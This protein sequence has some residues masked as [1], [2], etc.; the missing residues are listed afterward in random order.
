MPS[1]LLSA[2]NGFAL[3]FF[4]RRFKVAIFSH[5]WKNACLGNFALKPTQTRLNAF[6]FTENY[7]SHSSSL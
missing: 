1:P 5:I 2:S 7:L 6:I 4:N 3:A